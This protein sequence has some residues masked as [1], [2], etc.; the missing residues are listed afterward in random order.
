MKK[1]HTDFAAVPRSSAGPH[2]K[3]IAS[4]NNAIPSTGST[5][6]HVRQAGVGQRLG[7]Q[8][9]VTVTTCPIEGELCCR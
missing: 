6:L 8:V 1:E 7:L 2:A 5:G 4:S 9:D 3:A